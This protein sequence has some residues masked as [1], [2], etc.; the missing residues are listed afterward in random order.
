MIKQQRMYTKQ[1]TLLQQ[2]VCSSVR[3]SDI[4]MIPRIEA[5]KD[6]PFLAMNK[7][8][9]LSSTTCFKLQLIGENIIEFI[10]FQFKL[11]V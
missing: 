3:H 10:L 9:L 2:C 1:P 8:L 6:S 4:H 5:Y 11:F 7:V